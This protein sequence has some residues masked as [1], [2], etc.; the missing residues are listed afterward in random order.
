MDHIKILKSS[1]FSENVKLLVSSLEP[2]EEKSLSH[3]LEI[4]RDKKN[5]F[6]SKNFAH[7]FSSEVGSEL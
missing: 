2:L 6:P 4:S 5:S 3:F 7:F 1:Y